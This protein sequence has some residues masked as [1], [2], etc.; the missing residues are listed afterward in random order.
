MWRNI[1]L[2]LESNNKASQI[3]IFTFSKK[4]QASEKN[5][6][7]KKQNKTKNKNPKKKN[8]PLSL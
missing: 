1:V 6:K 5:E 7:N 4:T 8:K 3:H 2:Y